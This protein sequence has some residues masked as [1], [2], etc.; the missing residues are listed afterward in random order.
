MLIQSAPFFDRAEATWQG[1]FDPKKYLNEFCDRIDQYDTQVRAFLPESDR[2]KRLLHEAEQLLRRHPD[3]THRP[4]LFLVPVGVKDIFRVDGFP[5]KAGSNLPH[6]LF[7]GSEGPC[8]MALRQAGALIMGKTVT[9]EFA[10]MEPGPT[11]NPHDLGHTP[12]G[13]SS[14][15]AAA[16]AAGFCPAA[17]GTQTIGSIIR[18]ASFCGIVGFK[19]TYGRVPVGGILPL[20]PAMD[21]VGW[22]T[23][24]V[25]GSR[26]LASILLSNWTPVE[27]GALPTIGIPDE[28]YLAEVEPDGQRVFAIMLRKLDDA[29]YSIRNTKSLSNLKEISED[30]KRLLC[31]EMAMVHRGWF[32]RYEPLYRTG[33]AESIREGQKTSP[34]ELEELRNRGRQLREQLEKEMETEG[35]DLWISPASTGPAPEGL[36]STGNRILSAPWTY[37]GLPTISLPSGIAENGLPIGTQFITR[38]MADEKLLSWAEPIEKAL[39]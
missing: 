7:Q 33:T 16:V 6:V 24:E 5:T 1:D 29:G 8:V 21:H 38:F 13:S 30:A 14:G 12:G 25:S 37:A 36:T 19:P 27:P 20:A 18:P 15:S 31:G 9:T 4:P 26:L 35:I 34:E 32:S 3:P 17:L 2:R 23:Q 22:F 11:R 10:L 39:M 28:A